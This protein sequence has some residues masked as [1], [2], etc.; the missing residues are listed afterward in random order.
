M[1]ILNKPIEFEWDEGNSGKNWARHKV[2]DQECEEAFFDNNKKI[3]K[4]ILHSGKEERYILFGNTKKQRLL[5][6][7]FTVRNIRVRVISARDMNKKENKL[8]HG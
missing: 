8:Y 7:V 3:F 6:I 2:S 4:D 1:A 5:F